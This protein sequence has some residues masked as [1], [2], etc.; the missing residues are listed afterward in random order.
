MFVTWFFEGRIHTLLR[1]D[2]WMD[3]LLYAGIANIGI[4]LVGALVLLR[5]LLERGRLQWPR[6]RLWRGAGSRLTALAAAVGIGTGYFLLAGG[7][8]PGTAELINAFAQ[9]FVVS[10]A[11]VIVCWGL[12]G[13]STTHVLS[14]LERPWAAVAAAAAASLAFGVYH[15]AHSPP[16]NSPSMVA[17]LTVVGLGTSLFF[18]ATRDLLATI[19]FHNFPAVAGV[20]RALLDGSRT[21]ALADLQPALLGTAALSLVLVLAGERLLPRQGR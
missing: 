15:F 18:F 19:V 10:A 5:W 3:R 12:I 7:A 8:W 20:T 9:V 17:F 14:S 21:E 2:A 16:F 6:P 1:P 11:E 13:L 4:G